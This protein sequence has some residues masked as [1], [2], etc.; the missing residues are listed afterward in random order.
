MR[1]IHIPIGIALI[2]AFLAYQRLSGD[3]SQDLGNLLSDFKI[4]IVIAV[5]AVAVALAIFLLRIIVIKSIPNRES[6]NKEA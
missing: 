1:F 2:V 4:L 6:R 3:N 5:V